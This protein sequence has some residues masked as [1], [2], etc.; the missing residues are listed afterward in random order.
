MKCIIVDDE[1]L[2]LDILEEYIKN[3]NSLEL[4]ARCSNAIEAFNFLNENEVELIFLDIE[5]PQL[6]GLEFIKNIKNPPMVILTTAYSEYALQGY[7]LNIVDYLLKPI[8]FER[9]LKAVNKINMKN[10]SVQFNI[11]KQ[12]ENKEPEYIFVKIKDRSYKIYFEDIIFIESQR[13]YIKIQT[14]EKE[15]ICYQSIS[16]FETLLPPDKFIRVHRSFIVSKEKI[17]VLSASEIECGRYK[18]PTGGQYRD[19][20]L[21]I[22][23]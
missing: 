18:I 9:F 8:S 13:N 23:N 5:M 4:V 21:K 11:N 19:K 10:V 6:S 16:N 3:I 2:A 20:V 22:V 17:S 14:A 1:P 12:E 7:E 15:Y